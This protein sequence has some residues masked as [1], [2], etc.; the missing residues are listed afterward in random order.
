LGT[1][2]TKRCPR[3]LQ[4]HPRS[5]FGSRKNGYTKSYCRSCERTYNAEKARRHYAAH[6]EHRERR[7]LSNQRAQ[8]KRKYGITVEQFGEMKRAQGNLCAI[9]EEG[10]GHGRKDLCVDHR[11]DESQ[12]VRGLLCNRCNVAIG[13]LGDD[14]GLLRRAVN[15][16]E[17]YE[18]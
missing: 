13:L 10:P 11:H 6:P 17:K 18:P 12:A 3:C 16:L 2:A 15:Y 14:I 8:F 4:D 9:C 5:S 1:S 7:R